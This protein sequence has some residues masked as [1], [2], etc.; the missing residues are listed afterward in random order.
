MCPLTSYGLFYCKWQKFY[1]KWLKHKKG[2]PIVS[3]KL[4]SPDRYL[5]LILLDPGIQ[6]ILPCPWFS[7]IYLDILVTNWLSFLNRISYM[8]VCLQLTFSQFN[9]F[10]RKMQSS[11]LALADVSS[12]WLTSLAIPVP[13]GL[14]HVFHL[15]SGET[16]ALWMTSSPGSRGMW[17]AVYSKDKKYT[18][19]KRRKSIPGR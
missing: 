13:W 11:L 17:V 16:P 5:A 10:T 19:T 2:K 8:A 7:L 6:M 9:S 12:F 1:S 14:S 3:C 15:W 18:P 4:K